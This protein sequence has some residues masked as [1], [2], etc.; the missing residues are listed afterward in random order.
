MRF[1][2][3]ILHLMQEDWQVS[4]T[5]GPIYVIFKT[6]GQQ[7]NKIRMYVRRIYTLPQK[8]IPTQLKSN[9]YA[10]CVSTLK[11]TIPLIL[12][13]LMLHVCQAKLAA[14]AAGRTQLCKIHFSA[15]KK[16][17]RIQNVK[18]LFILSVLLTSSCISFESRWNLGSDWISE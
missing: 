4:T 5:W 8:F 10:L 12:S 14:D 1:R 16:S 18:S 9:L 11:P 6:D 2:I 15:V 17:G 13:S 7:G 3:R